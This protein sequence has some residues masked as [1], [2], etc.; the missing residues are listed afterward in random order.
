MGK[1]PVV[2]R[3]VYYGTQW[4]R[5]SRLNDTIRLDIYY[6]YVKGGGGVGGANPKDWEVNNI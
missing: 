6:V 4:R 2:E 3:E 5:L 1:D